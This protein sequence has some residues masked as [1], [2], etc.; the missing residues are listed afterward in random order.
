ME[1]GDLSKV[2][3]LYLMI[4][5]ERMLD[6]SMRLNATNKAQTMLY[7]LDTMKRRASAAAS[8]PPPTAEPEKP[9]EPEQPKY[10]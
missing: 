1:Q 9:K 8:A 2:S 5:A 10:T 3:I 6:K 7:K 4:K